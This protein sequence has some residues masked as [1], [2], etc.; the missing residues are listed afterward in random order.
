M[1]SILFLGLLTGL[2]NLQV[3]PALG[4][5]NM[6][7]RRRL[8]WAVAFGLAEALMPLIGLLLG[9]QLHQSFENWA[10]K[11]GPVVLVLCGIAV[12]V[13]ALRKCDVAAVASS[14]WAIIGL[15]LSLSIDNLLAGLGM[16][17]GGA[18]VLISALFIGGVSTLVGLVGLYAGLFSRRWLRGS[19]DLVCGGFLLLLGLCGL[20]WN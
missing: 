14:K 3:T 4:L 20:F 13:M 2:D 1:K 7:P 10:E 18:P 9:T 16:G 5:L 19:T 6:T 8:A 17:A 11:I 12:I 15:P